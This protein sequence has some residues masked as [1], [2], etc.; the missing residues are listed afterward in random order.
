MIERN[1]SAGA[2]YRRINLFGRPGVGKSTVAAHLYHEMKVRDC[3]VE[4]VNEYVK[5]WAYMNR[6]IRS[7]DQVYCFGKQINAEDRLLCHAGLDYIISDSPILIQCCYAELNNDPV[8]HALRDLV[9][10]FDIGFK[11]LNI[12]LDNPTDDHDD[13]GRFHDLESARA[14]GD[15]MKRV[16]QEE[17][18][19]YITWDP[20]D[21]AGLTRLILAKLE[22]T[23]ENSASPGPS[24][25]PEHDRPGRRSLLRAAL[26][27]GGGAVRELLSA[28]RRV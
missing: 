6:P 3:R 18:E 12:F 21:P 16:L 11:P 26:Q 13:H 25:L 19:E 4:L 27:R 7:F 24:N 20:R 28:L 1:S 8:R 5:G 17:Y 10:L 15:I 2:K 14:A 23:N 9:R 22:L